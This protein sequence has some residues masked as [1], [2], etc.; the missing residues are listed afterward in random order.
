MK[1]EQMIIDRW[2]TAYKKKES[3]FP[4]FLNIETINQCNL[5]CVMCPIDK[6]TRAR[7]TMSMELYE[8][9]IEECRN[10][11]HIIK[12]FSLFMQGEPLLDNLLERR[13]KIAKEAGI[14][15]V[16]IA[17]NGT[18]LTPSRAKK[19]IDSGLDSII[20]SLEDISKNFHEKVRVGSKYEK[21][22]TNLETL[23]SI[24]NDLGLAKPEITVRML[25]FKENEPQREIFIDHWKT[26]V[27]EVIIQPLHNWG[28]T[29]PFGRKVSYANS[30]CDYLWKSMVILID[31]RVPLCC[32]D[33]DGVYTLGN[34]YDES[35]YDIWHGE[36]YK[37]YR[38][39]Y[40]NNQIELC[41]HCNWIPGSVIT[42]IRKGRVIYDKNK[43][44]KKML[45][46]T[47]ER[48]LPFVDPKI[49]GAEI[50]YEH[51]HR[52]Y[53]ALHFVKDKKVLDLACGEGYG[54]KLY[55]IKYLFRKLRKNSSK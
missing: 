53:F 44:S 47:G 34:V 54:S 20:I 35:I 28:G 4:E 31:G 39:K 22:I 23:I 42:H 43:N 32:L 10:Y 8:K 27:D 29:E 40:K 2:D 9:I 25:A 55:L 3:L 5:N 45:E 37:L 16:Q 11:T 46:W 6:M 52:Y 12:N 18:L 51:L 38:K 33:Y 41:T 48:Y 24:R 36:K 1:D 26:K 21:I 13:I 7:G 17:T 49:S 15:N 14:P 50:H 19:L 30:K